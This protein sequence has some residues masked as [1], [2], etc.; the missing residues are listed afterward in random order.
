MGKCQ[1]GL[2]RK[3][4]KFQSVWS[5]SGSYLPAHSYVEDVLYA[6]EMPWS[7][8]KCEYLMDLLQVALIYFLVLHQIRGR[9]II[10]EL[11]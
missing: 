5:Y 3:I 11:D 2:S 9:E 6:T 7:K 4:V 8:G 1:D 10:T